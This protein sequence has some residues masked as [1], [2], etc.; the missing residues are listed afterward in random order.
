M[1]K[2]RSPGKNDD[3]YPPV[4]YIREP[5][6]RHGERKKMTADRYLWK[7][8]IFLEANTAIMAKKL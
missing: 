5:N 2:R 3:G 8:F 7:I 4:R 1:I 6:V